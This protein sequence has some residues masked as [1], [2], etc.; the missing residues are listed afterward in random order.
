MASDTAALT[1]WRKRRAEARLIR[2]ERQLRN[3]DKHEDWE[4]TFS[5]WG[6]AQAAKYERDRAALID[7]LNGLCVA[8]GVEHD[9]R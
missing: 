8:L 1:G 4:R 2:L 6:P 3:L 7:S 9:Y 5:R